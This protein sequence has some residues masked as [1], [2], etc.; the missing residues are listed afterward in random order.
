MCML[1]KAW[2]GGEGKGGEER[3]GEGIE[4]GALHGITGLLV[5]MS[6]EM[7]RFGGKVPG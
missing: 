5:R 2:R 6:Q 3:G 7:P 1:Y 4:S